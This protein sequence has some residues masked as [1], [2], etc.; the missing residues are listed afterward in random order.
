MAMQRRRPGPRRRRRR[1]SA[2]TARRRIVRGKVA[3]FDYKDVATLQRM[4]TAHGKMHSR[5]RSG[6]N[7]KEQ[8]SAALAIK[9]ARYMALLPYVS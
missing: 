3:E 6:L 4:L 2:D 8:R 9:R 5:K 7:A 1:R